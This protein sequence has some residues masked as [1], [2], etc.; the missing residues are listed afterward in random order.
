MVEQQVRDAI[1]TE[2]K[3]QAEREPESLRVE[4]TD[5]RLV[6]HG[7]INIDELV[8]AIVGSVAGGP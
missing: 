8:A 1:V 4:E 5:S 7:T 2:L 6:A 3:R